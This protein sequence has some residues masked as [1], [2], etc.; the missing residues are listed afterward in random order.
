M[1]HFIYQFTRSLVWLRPWSTELIDY[2]FKFAY[3]TMKNIT[4]ARSARASFI[5]GHFIDV[6]VLSTTW[7]WPVLQLCGRRE[8]IMTSVQVYNIAFLPKK[9]WFQFNSRIVRTHFAS[10]MI[11]NN[12]EIIAETRSYIF[13]WRSR[14]RRR[15]FCRNSLTC[16]E[17]EIG[18]SGQR[19]TKARTRLN[20]NRNLKH[21]SGRFQ[22]ILRAQLPYFKISYYLV[23]ISFIHDEPVM[24]ICHY[25]NTWRLIN[26]WSKAWPSVMTVRAQFFLREAD[27][28]SRHM[29]RLLV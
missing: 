9:R 1:K 28:S 29:T 13:G 4:F 20:H 10:M 23:Y 16:G 25:K 2:L 21:I 3:L 15:C 7:K 18:R 6:L 17:R 14:S 24:A 8:H 12:W 26:L 19:K 22:I 11:L 27:H 5:F